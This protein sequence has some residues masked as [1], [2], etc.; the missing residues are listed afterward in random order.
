MASTALISKKLN[1]YNE[2]LKIGIANCFQSLVE[3][4]KKPDIYI[5]CQNDL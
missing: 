3:V 2:L 5:L 4:K 1:S